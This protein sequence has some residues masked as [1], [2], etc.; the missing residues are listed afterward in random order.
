MNFFYF[1]SFSAFT[2]YWAV[3]SS[4]NLALLD[5]MPIRLYYFQFAFISSLADLINHSLRF[6]AI[7]V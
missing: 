2:R 1:V 6:K 7:S 3:W 5:D 4:K